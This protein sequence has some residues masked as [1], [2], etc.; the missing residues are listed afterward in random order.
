MLA[1]AYTLLIDWMSENEGA[2]QNR[3]AGPDM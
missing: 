3:P 1:V 2:P